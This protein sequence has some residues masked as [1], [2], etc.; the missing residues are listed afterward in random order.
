MCCLGVGFSVKNANPT[1]NFSGA[2]FSQVK[3]TPTKP[4]SASIVKEDENDEETA[5]QQ[6]G[7][8]VSV[9]VAQTEAEQHLLAS[10]QHGESPAPRTESPNGEIAVEER[11]DGQAS[12]LRKKLM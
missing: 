11:T 4:A 3:P 2:L 1:K 10:E 9:V 12:P 5:G 6:R 7:A 8:P